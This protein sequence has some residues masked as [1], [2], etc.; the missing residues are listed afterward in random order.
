MRPPISGAT[1]KTQSWESGALPSKIAGPN[2]RAGLTE[3]PSRATPTR[4]QAPMAMQLLDREFA[5]WTAGR[6]DGPAR[7]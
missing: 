1:M 7:G 2:D 4:W 3:V 5:R 6:V